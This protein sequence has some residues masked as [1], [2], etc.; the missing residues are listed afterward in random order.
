MADLNPI[1]YWEKL[2]ALPNDSRRKTIFVAV[3]VSLVCAGLVSFTSVVLR[4]LH[5][6]NLQQERERQMAE[7][8][9]A[10][11]GLA[12]VL[13]DAG[14][15]RLEVRVV[16]LAT[17]VVAADMDPADYDYEARQTDPTSTDIIPEA[18]DVA[19]IS[20]RPRLA[21]V[22][23]VR[24]G[25]NLVLVVLPIY[26]R[27]Y[28]STIRAYL[29]LEGDVSTIAALSIYQQ[30]ETPGLGSRI[31]N[32]D[33]LNNWRNLPAFGAEGEVQVEVVTGGAAQP[34]EVDALSGATRSSA[35]VSNMVRFWLGPSGFGPFLDH[36]RAGAQ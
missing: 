12:T 17:G 27:G 25:T 6:K 19:G 2:L 8:I 9:A 3:V 32:A 36:I 1:S 20:R 4:P 18:D 10:L 15:T 5:E 14:A 23:L 31:S 29:A 21:P 34:F 33:W 24:D 26:G 7:M 35:G 30:G 28:Q 13:T 11:P 16:E 22:Y